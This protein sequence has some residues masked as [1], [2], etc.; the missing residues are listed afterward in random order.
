VLL[1]GIALIVVTVIAI[2]RPVRTAV[3]PPGA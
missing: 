3:T 1:S 2:R